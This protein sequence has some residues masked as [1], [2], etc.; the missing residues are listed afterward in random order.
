MAVLVSA[1]A[2]LARASRRAVQ[3]H[4]AMQERALAL[5]ALASRAAIYIANVV[6]DD[7]VLY[8]IFKLCDGYT[9]ELSL[10]GQFHYHPAL[11][12]ILIFL[13]GPMA[14]WELYWLLYAAALCDSVAVHGKFAVV[15]DG[16]ASDRLGRCRG[17]CKRQYEC[18]CLNHSE[19]VGFCIYQKKHEGGCAPF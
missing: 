3:E 6:I 5:I 18:D 19:H 11:L 2:R 10:L 1:T 7:V 8:G 17:R 12:W 16:H 14:G 4:A 13:M 15:V 9:S